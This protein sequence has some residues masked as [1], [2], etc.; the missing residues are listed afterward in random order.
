MKTYQNQYLDQHE[1][2]K[3]TSMNPSYISALKGLGNMSQRMPTN[4]HD[5]MNFNSKSYDDQF[6]KRS[7]RENIAVRS[8]IHH[9]PYY[10]SGNLI[11]DVIGGI[12]NSCPT[13][14][15]SQAWGSVYAAQNPP[16]V[17]SS[18]SYGAFHSKK[19][20][21]HG[22]HEASGLYHLHNKKN[23]GLD[24]FRRRERMQKREEDIYKMGRM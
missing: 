4:V 1:I 16:C 5:A 24:T 20:R 23:L 10:P 8:N 17:S 11:P 22:A 13:G 6:T 14:E 7:V 9:N 3:N 19:H 2:V 18:P 12:N 15:K 21:Q